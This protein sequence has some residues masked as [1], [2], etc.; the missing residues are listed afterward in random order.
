MRVRGS[1]QQSLQ[2]RSKANLCLNVTVPGVAAVQN[3]IAALSR[4]S[5]TAITTLSSEDGVLRDSV[6][7]NGE[8]C[9]KSGYV[10]RNESGHSMRFWIN[11]EGI[12]GIGCVYH[13]N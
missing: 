11:V 6:G 1:S 3:S 13:V 12:A 10:L 5:T 8:E 7:L 4:A 9:G 2:F